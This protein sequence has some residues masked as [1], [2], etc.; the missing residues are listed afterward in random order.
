MYGLQVFDLRI[1]SKDSAGRV[2]PYSIL[3]GTDPFS[4]KSRIPS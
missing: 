1:S 4:L 3:N 2:F